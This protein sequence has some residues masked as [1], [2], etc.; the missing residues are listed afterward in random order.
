MNYIPKMYIIVLSI[1]LLPFII[2]LYQGYLKASSSDQVYEI[3]N[4][5]LCN[6]I[7]PYIKN[8][9]NKGDSIR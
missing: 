4:K 9:R 8:H 6:E 7:F 3:N 1:I 5:K 2:N